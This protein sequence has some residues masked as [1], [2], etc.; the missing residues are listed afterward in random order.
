MNEDNSNADAPCSLQILGLLICHKRNSDILSP[1][2]KKFI[3]FDVLSM[4]L[5][6]RFL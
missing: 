2:V 3:S 4:C 5:D 1:F 6:N